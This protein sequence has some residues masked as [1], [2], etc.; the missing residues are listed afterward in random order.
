MPDI[1]DTRDW[2]FRT[3]QKPYE[4]IG[5]AYHQS[6]KSFKI[7]TG[8]GNLLRPNHDLDVTGEFKPDAKA[9]IRVQDA[10]GRSSEWSITADYDKQYVWLDGVVLER[11]NLTEKGMGT[12]VKNGLFVIHAGP[13]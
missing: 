13:G 10:T 12:S 2:L 6:T 3:L 9:V 11:L 1:E 8:S 5:I 4:L 7:Y